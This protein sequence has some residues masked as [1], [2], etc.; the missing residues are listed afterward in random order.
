M[1]YSVINDSARAYIISENPL[2]QDDRLY[3]ELGGGTYSPYKY[4]ASN[5]ELGKYIT[6]PSG[7][8][9]SISLVMYMGDISVKVDDSFDQKDSNQFSKKDRAR[10]FF[11]LKELFEKFVSLLPAG[12]ELLCEAEDKDKVV[13]AKKHRIYKKLGFSVLEEGSTL[14][15]YITK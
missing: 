1:S 4:I 8:V 2:T 12:I 13:Q 9:V 7:Q 14:L 3:V 11:A 6:L 5:F 15:A 10:I